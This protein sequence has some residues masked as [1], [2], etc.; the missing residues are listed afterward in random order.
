LSK[1]DAALGLMK[2]VKYNGNILELKSGEFFFSYSDGLTE[3]RNE[4]GFFYG[5][6]RLFNLLLYLKNYTA[7]EIG[8][9]IIE[10]LDNFVGDRRNNDDLSL[11]IVKRI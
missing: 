3:A 6:E 9:A 2:D 7:K 5:T 8:D 10:D 4:A 11:L 1:G